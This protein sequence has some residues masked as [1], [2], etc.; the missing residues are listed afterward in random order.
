MITTKLPWFSVIIPTYL[1]SKQLIDC[2]N[3]IKKL[4]YPRDKFEVIVVDDGNEPALD[5][6]EVF[7]HKFNLKLIRQN[8]SGP[9]KARNKGVSQ[10]K[11]QYLIFLDDDCIPSHDW[12]KKIEESV[13]NN[14][15]YLIGGKTI[16]ALTKNYYSTASQILVDY[17]YS[18]NDKNPKAYRFFTSNNMIVASDK[19]EELKGFD[20][21]FPL[22][23]GEDREFCDKWLS[24][25][26]KMYYIPEII[27]YHY[28]SLTLTKYF[29]QHFN[30]GRGAFC[31]HQISAKRNKTNVKVAPI[32]FYVK[33]LSYP[34]YQESF[35]KSL[36][37]LLL[38][39]LSQLANVTGF[40]VEKLKA[41]DNGCVLF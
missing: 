20:T 16:N 13:F 26:Y 30:Y 22:A 24:Q 10:A 23:A 5:L 2:L 4:D 31:F 7:E 17:F 21:R 1:R 33:L 3:I 35:P 8:N 28:H 40:F 27:I 15:D 32:T 18:L 36:V 9:A 25:G 6:E 11:G 39:I 14:P 34:L 12:L 29:W 41:K 37:M 38:L 19:F